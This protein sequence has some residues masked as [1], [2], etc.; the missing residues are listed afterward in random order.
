MG[1]DRY[2]IIKHWTSEDEKRLREM[3]RKGCRPGQI[4][5]ALK[6]TPKAVRNRA[7]QIGLTFG[8]IKI[9]PHA[10]GE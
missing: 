2:P 4:A 6:R 3:V 5:E 7:N 1:S 10:L 8:G 9:A